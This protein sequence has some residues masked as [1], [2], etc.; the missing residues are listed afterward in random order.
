MPT[1]QE[2][3]KEDLRRVRGL[4]KLL[5]R[6]NLSDRARSKLESALRIQKAGVRMRLKAMT[7]PGVS[8]ASRTAGGS[9]LLRDM[10][11][12]G[13]ASRNTDI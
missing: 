5:Q 11:N 8:G 9:P 10:S 7:A 1:P 2:K 13:T 3:L 6:P 4:E 12:P